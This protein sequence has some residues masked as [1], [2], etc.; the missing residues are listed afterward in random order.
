MKI[1]K[2]IIL[3]FFALFLITSCG[4]KD[5]IEEN[6]LVESKKNMSQIFNL[7]TTTGKDIIINVK[8]FY[9]PYLKKIKLL[10]RK[11]IHQSL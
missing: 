2:I 7:K 6:V 4:D 5:K 9:Y 3:S 1:K 11:F 10:L 8:I